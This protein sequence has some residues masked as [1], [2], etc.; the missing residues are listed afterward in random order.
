MRYLD[1]DDKCGYEPQGYKDNCILI[2]M[3]KKYNL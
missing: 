1:E 3:T 2:F